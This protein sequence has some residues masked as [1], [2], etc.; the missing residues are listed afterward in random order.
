SAPSPSR[1]NERAASAEA[2]VDVGEPVGVPFGLA[3]RRGEERSLELLRDRPT[4][5]LPY[6][7]VIHLADRG[8]LGG[9]A[10]EEALVSVIE[11][12]ANEVLLA[13][14]VTQVTGGVE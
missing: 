5:S 11:I 13:D 14:L 12:A 3:L 7:P 10:G 1:S 8:D 4:V 2:S 9:G 6:R